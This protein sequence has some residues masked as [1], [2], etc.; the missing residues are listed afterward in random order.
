MNW[1]AFYYGF[2]LLGI[3]ALVVLL[4]LMAAA[5][6]YSR[7]NILKSLMFYFLVV[8]IVNLVVDAVRKQLPSPI[9]EV[10]ESEEVSQ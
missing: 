10:I 7:Q 4:S 9:K 1:P 6:D 5:D 8:Y 3:A 2:K